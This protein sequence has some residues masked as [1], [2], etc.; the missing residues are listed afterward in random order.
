MMRNDRGHQPRAQ[1]A[2]A[3]G[4]RAKAQVADRLF[5]AG[6]TAIYSLLVAAVI[7]ALR[8]YPG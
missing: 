3:H 6:C 1:E 2:R 8:L 5:I 4:A 7:V